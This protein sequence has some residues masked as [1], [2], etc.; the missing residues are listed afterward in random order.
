MYINFWYPVCIANELTDNA[1][2][3]ARIL[4][5]PLVAFRDH[6][7]QA[8]VLADTCI[9][10]GGSLG[11]GWGV[12]HEVT[13]LNAV[14]R[15]L[16]ALSRCAHRPE[17][18]PELLAQAFSLFA[19]G[20]PRPVH[21]SVPIDVLE[22]H[23]EGDWQPVA[24]PG[25]PAPDPEQIARA[26]GLLRSAR[27]PVILTG[28]G[29]A[30]ADVT[31]IAER[32][33]AVVIASNAGK[34]VV[35]DDHA[36]SLG[37][38]TVRP[39]V[40]D[41]LAGADAV[42][43][44][45]TELSETDSFVPRME[46]SG[47]II[48]VDLDARKMNDL[49]PASVSIIADA[50]PAIAELMNALSKGAPAEG[51][52]GTVAG[53]RGRIADGLSSSEAQHMRVLRVLREA[54]PLEAMVMGDACQLVYSGAFQFPVSMPRRWHYAAGYCALGYAF[55]NAIGAKIANPDVPVV[56]I[57]G[58]GGAMFTIQELV[59]AAE[60][61]QPI[62]YIIWEN[63]G[64]KQIQDDMRAGNVPRVG[65]DGINPDFLGLARAMHCLA[66]E[67]DSAD[68]FANAIIEAQSVER[69]TLILLHENSE[70]LT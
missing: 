46:F 24:L 14:T 42:L 68:G 54:L 34:G 64:L 41:Y 47:P 5:L 19:S 69:P 25:P 29:A 49:Y 61:K 36:L 53:L 30:G 18:V 9:H 62:P 13:D 33:G 1:P 44:I 11:K 40:Q 51:G 43:A 7:G 3:R 58:D 2:L 4:G 35:R 16:T 31:A 10:R 12:L 55:P 8:H 20:R 59:T 70:W 21:I 38:A 48:R 65:V 26:A 6:A 32:L 66:V 39:E 22:T 15:P 45:G 57:A 27:R 52:A 23:V 56:A 28:G 60:L 67:P 17:D 37:A 63:G 50:A